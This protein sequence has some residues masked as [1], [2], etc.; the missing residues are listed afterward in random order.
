MTTWRARSG[1]SLFALASLSACTASTS[2]F[3]TQS[4]PSP[5]HD[6]PALPA[7]AAASG[8][9][10]GCG[11]DVPA[12]VPAA[13]RYYAFLAR[14]SCVNVEGSGGTWVTS[15]L[16]P[17]APPSIRDVACAFAWRPS[18]RDATADVGALEALRP[19]L[20][21][22]SAQADSAAPRLSPSSITAFPPAAVGVGP[23]P[24]GVTGC[25]VCGRVVGR[26]AYAILP[27]DHLNLHMMM[28]STDSGKLASFR[29]TP[30]APTLQVFSVVLPAAPESANYTQGRFLLFEGAP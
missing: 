5:S 23:K 28:I 7:P 22:P 17:A 9:A 26:E 25:D 10:D 18:A 24:T 12:R 29:V 16:F 11:E 6:E 1:A 13:T 4:P 21:T 20:L 3:D 19:E 15:P 14:G 2:T 8:N 27:A 30:G